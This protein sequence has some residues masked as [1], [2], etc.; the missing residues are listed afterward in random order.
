MERVDFLVDVFWKG[1]LMSSL[2][3][4]VQVGGDGE[5][6]GGDICRHSS[7]I[8]AI[9]G[10]D[11]E[12]CELDHAHPYTH[13]ATHNDDLLRPRQDVTPSPIGHPLTHSPFKSIKCVS[14]VPHL[15][16]ATNSPKCLIPHT[17]EPR[18]Q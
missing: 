3:L 5:I 6:V 14:Y 15:A 13:K 2:A 17:S 9:A 4:F 7:D 8:I 18:A 16:R 12:E 1:E 11:L 10:W